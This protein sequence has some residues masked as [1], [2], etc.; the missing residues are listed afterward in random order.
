[1]YRCRESGAIISYVTEKYDPTRTISFEKFEDKMHM[2]QWLFFQASGQGS[3]SSLLP[4]V[5][6]QL[7]GK[8]SPYYG[9][10]SWFM[11]FASE[12]IQSAIVRYQKEIM[13]I[14]GVL[15]GV[16]S[17]QRWLVGEKFSAADVAFITYV[18]L[19]RLIETGQSSCTL[20][21]DL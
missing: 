5:I 7:T 18:P 20:S 3:A 10:A 13:R 1:M 6:L 8:L 2:L 15:E 4:E 21:P 14:L 19:I 11:L 16:L 9:Q 12:K 17:K